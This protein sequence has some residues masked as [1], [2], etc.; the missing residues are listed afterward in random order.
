MLNYQ[1]TT[2]KVKE[3]QREMLKKLQLSFSDQ[4]K[5]MNYCKKKKIKFLSTAFDIDNLKFLLKNKVDYI[6]V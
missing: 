2:N 5:L 4:K 1:K 3:T 6:K